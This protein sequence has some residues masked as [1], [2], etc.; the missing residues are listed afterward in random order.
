MPLLPQSATAV[1][2]AALVLWIVFFVGSIKVSRHTFWLVESHRYPRI[3]GLFPIAL[4]GIMFFSQFCFRLAPS[5]AW[6]WI[7]LGCV[8][9]AVPVLLTA[10]TVTQVFQQCTGDL[11][12]PL[13]WSIIAPTL[14]AC[15]FV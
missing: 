10:E 4:L 2:V 6:E 11:V 7:G 3:F 1:T 12:R 15:F 5:I 13:P 9:T 14:L 8:M